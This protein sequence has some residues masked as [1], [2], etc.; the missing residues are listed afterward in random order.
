MD[1]TL[2]A[3]LL[4]LAACVLA[5]GD[6]LQ[7]LFL[8]IRPFAHS[9]P[10]SPSAKAQ[11]SASPRS[12]LQSLARDLEGVDPARWRRALEHLPNYPPQ[13]LSRVL[14][15]LLEG[16]PTELRD[17]IADVLLRHGGED[18]L[19]PLHRYFLGRQESYEAHLEQQDAEVLMGQVQAFPQSRA[20]AYKPRFGPPGPQAEGRVLPFRSRRRGPKLGDMSFPP[21]VLSTDPETRAQALI[22]LPRQG[23]PQ[24][25]EL[26][27]RVVTSD[28]EA[29]VRGAAI[30]GL[31]H[32]PA[33]DRGLEVLSRATQ[34]SDASVRWNACYALGRLGSPKAKRALRFAENDPDGSVRL[35]ARR[36]L[37]SLGLDPPMAQ[38]TS[39]TGNHPN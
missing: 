39:L 6:E 11:A 14:V 7:E 33:E 24:A 22:Q 28:P 13:E 35:A 21:E 25:Y 26:L 23:H 30:S 38:V 18:V 31:A 27:C 5:Y 16:P 17:Q 15:P 12:M 32:L 36:A 3:T 9:N 19:E 10:S 1:L 37:E 2:I 29:L 4:L 20:V 8:G 34:D